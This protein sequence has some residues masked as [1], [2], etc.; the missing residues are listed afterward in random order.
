MARDPAPPKT[1]EVLQAQ[2]CHYFNGSGITQHTV[3]CLETGPSV[4][5]HAFTLGSL[6]ASCSVVSDSA[7]PWTAARQAPLSVGFSRQEYCSEL[8]CPP[9]GGLL[10]PG[11]EPQSL[12][13][14]LA[15]QVLYH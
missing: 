3:H 13:P 5:L 2:D 12:S 9:P 1:L 6:C 14:A 15:R 8:P 4:L 11:T 10:N 7:T